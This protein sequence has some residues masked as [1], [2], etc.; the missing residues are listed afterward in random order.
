MTV[1]NDAPVSFATDAAS[2]VAMVA[3]PDKSLYHVDIY[4]GAIRRIAAEEISTPLPPPPGMSYLSDLMPA[5]AVNGY[6]PIEL[7]RSNGERAAGNGNTLTIDGSTFTKGLGVHAASDVSYALSG[8]TTFAAKI[9]VDGVGFRGSVTFRVW[10]DGVLKYES[11]V[12]RGGQAAVPVS[13]DVTGGSMLRL[14]VTTGGDSDAADHADWADATLIC[15]S[16]SHQVP[17]TSITRPSASYRFAVGDIISLTGTATDPED[18]TLPA[19][20]LS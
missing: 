1:T 3:G 16:S 14:A 5:R 7:D 10:V 17:V 12:L 13:V 18:G 20:A 15:S 9:G 6:G 8:C 2:P 11:A 19:T 4:S